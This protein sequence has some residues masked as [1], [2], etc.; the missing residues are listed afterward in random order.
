MQLHA[1]KN[2]S[3]PFKRRKRVGRGVGSG[4]G[5]TCTRGVKGAGSRSG[6]KARERYEGGQIPLYRK[7]PERGFTR[8]RFQKRLHAISLAQIDKFFK[9]GEIVNIETLRK[10]GLLKGESF[11]VKLLSTGELTKKVTVEAQALTRQAEEKLKKAK[12]P[13]TIVP[14]IKQ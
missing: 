9:D 6:W 10:Y 14:M 12:V 13:Y 4:R 5:K 11:G 8:G 1:L 3:R 2:S 7:L